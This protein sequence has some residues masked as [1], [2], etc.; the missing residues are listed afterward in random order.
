MLGTFLNVLLIDVWAGIFWLCGFRENK[1]AKE[2]EV[3]LNYF[4]R[5]VQIITIPMI[6]FIMYLTCKQIKLRRKAA[7][8]LLNVDQQI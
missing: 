1:K 7:V 4:T 5:T 8:E 2:G 6:L 3:A